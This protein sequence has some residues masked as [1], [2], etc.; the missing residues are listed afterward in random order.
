MAASTMKS[1]ES[2]VRG[3]HVYKDVWAPVLGDTSILEI[4]ELN[5]HNRYA[6]ATKVDDLVVGHVPRENYGSQSQL[7]IRGNGQN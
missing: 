2:V 4:E 5:I 7:K 3:Y 6:V 1:I